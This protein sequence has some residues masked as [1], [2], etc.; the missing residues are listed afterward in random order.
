M[1]DYYTEECQSIGL[2]HPWNNNTFFNNLLKQ[3]TEEI[4]KDAEQDKSLKTN[5]IIICSEC[6]VPSNRHDNTAYDIIRS[7]PN[8][9]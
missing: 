3:L 9:K 4:D 1:Q 5:N 8:Y 6:K 7:H 2:Y